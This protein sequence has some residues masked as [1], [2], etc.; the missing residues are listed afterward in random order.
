MNGPAEIVRSALTAAD[1]GEWRRVAS[2]IEPDA[3]RRIQQRQVG[4]FAAMPLLDAPGPGGGALISFGDQPTPEMAR[5]RVNSLPGAPTVG[6]LGAISPDEFYVRWQEGADL[7]PRWWERVLAW[8]LP[9]FAEDHGLERPTQVLG[10]V[11]ED[12]RTA[13]VVYR[14]SG[15]VSEQAD[16]ITLT[17]SGETWRMQ[18]N[19]FSMGLDPFQARAATLAFGKLARPGLGLILWWII[20]AMWRRFAPQGAANR[21]A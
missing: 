3:L 14:M 2:M 8:L 9:K 15:S 18:L 11:M 10:E 5:T 12:A 7:R 13:H 6:E 20:K 21:S 19:D 16:V 4:M 17:R 1:R